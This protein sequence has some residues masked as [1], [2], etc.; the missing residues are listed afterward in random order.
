MTFAEAFDLIEAGQGRWEVRYRGT[1]IV[2][3]NVLRVASGFDARDWTNI[4]L[5][6]HSTMDDALRQLVKVADP[7]FLRVA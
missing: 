5:G 2:V 1:I 4:S 7:A 6:I 3:G